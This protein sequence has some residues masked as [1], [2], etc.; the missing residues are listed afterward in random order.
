MLVVG[1]LLWPT[2]R[3]SSGSQP[4]IPRC[5]TDTRVPYGASKN[6]L[7]GRRGVYRTPVFLLLDGVTLT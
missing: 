3:L 7:D 5:S 4:R 1:T 6:E 2:L